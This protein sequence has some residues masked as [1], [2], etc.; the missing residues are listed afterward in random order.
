VGSYISVSEYCGRVS[1]SEL[2][3]GRELQFSGL[4]NI[5]G[6]CT[7]F[8]WACIVAWIKLLLYQV[9]LFILLLVFHLLFSTYIHSYS[10]LVF[11]R[12]FYLGSC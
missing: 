3:V 5:F 6:G 1:P 12:G 8:S 11:P 4:D 9:L 10:K 7:C 2:R